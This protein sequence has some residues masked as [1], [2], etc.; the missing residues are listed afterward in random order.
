[1]WQVQKGSSESWKV[2]QI[3]SHLDGS[4]LDAIVEG[5]LVGILK[6]VIPLKVTPLDYCVI[7]ARNFTLNNGV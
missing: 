2:F 4:A 5:I 6:K 1:M 3:Y 7:I